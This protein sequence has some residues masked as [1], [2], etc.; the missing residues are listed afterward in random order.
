M[1][2][3]S[4]N[5]SLFGLTAI[6]MLMGMVASQ[7]VAQSALQRQLAGAMQSKDDSVTKSGKPK[8]P[9]W[10]AKKN[11]KHPGKGCTITFASG[12]SAIGYLGPSDDWNEA[13]FLVSGPNVPAPSKAKSVK[14]TLSTDGE[15]DRTVTATHIGID[16]EPNGLVIFLLPTI[17]AALDVMQN[18]E[19]V[20]V[21]MA[22]TQIFASA[23]TKG[24]EARD[25]MRACLAGQN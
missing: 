12:D 18:E 23:W 22:G 14:V 19:G 5:R 1:P 7:A 16:D 17:D 4:I 21:S 9:Q 15:P 11:G 10:Y 25:K 8:P 2:A 3:M 13:F 20:R 24:H 6:I